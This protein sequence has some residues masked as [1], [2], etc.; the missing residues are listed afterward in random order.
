MTQAHAAQPS[1][2][3]PYVWTYLALLALATASWML[4]SLHIPGAIAIGLS[5]GA[6]KALLVVGYFMHL[7]EEPFSFKLILAVAIA[8]VAIFIGLAVLDPVTRVRGADVDALR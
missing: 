1:S 6:V 2:P 5:I 4:A 7:R 3:A 8:L